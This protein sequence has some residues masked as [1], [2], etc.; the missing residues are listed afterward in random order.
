M[1]KRGRNQEKNLR[2]KFSD[3]KLFNTC[4][5]SSLFLVPGPPQI[6]MGLILPL[7]IQTALFGV[8]S[9]GLPFSVNKE[10]TE[11]LVPL[12]IKPSI[13]ALSLGL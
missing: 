11:P 7:T 5:F 13:P 10:N 2:K 9:C 1:E 8:I 6:P 4:L 3:V 12:F